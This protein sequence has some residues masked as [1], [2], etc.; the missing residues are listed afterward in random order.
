MEIKALAEEECK[1]HLTSSDEICVFKPKL[2]KLDVKYHEDAVHFSRINGTTTRYNSVKDA[3]KVFFR[4]VYWPSSLSAIQETGSSESDNCSLNSSSSV[5]EH[6]R[7]T[8]IN[9]QLFSSRHHPYDVKGCTGTKGQCQLAGFDEC[10]I[11]SETFMG[12]V[13]VRAHGWEHAYQC[14]VIGRKYSVDRE[15]I[16]KSAEQINAETCD[17]LANCAIQSSDDP[18]KA[19]IYLSLHKNQCG[20]G[21]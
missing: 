17:R 13:K 16:R 4:A 9:T 11:Q 18:S 3:G 20:T 15:V 21:R 6:Y 8:L 12:E 19:Q 1:S 5:S 14:S 10:T 7:K 2:S